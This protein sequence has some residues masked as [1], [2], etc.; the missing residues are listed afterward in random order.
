MN[1]NYLK[2]FLFCLIFLV[3]GLVNVKAIS[4]TVDG[5]LIKVTQSSMAF[6]SSNKPI[7][8]IGGSNSYSKA[9]AFK[10]LGGVTVKN[11]SNGTGY[12]S[13]PNGEYYVFAETSYGSYPSTK[14]T[15]NDSCDDQY[16]N[17]TKTGTFTL[18]RCYIK[19][20][21]ESGPIAVSKKSIGDSCASGYKIDDSK[22]SVKENTCYTTPLTVSGA[23]LGY[24]YCRVVYS[25]TC[26]KGT[27]SGGGTTPTVPAPSISSLSLSSGKISFKSGTK[28]YNVT[29][30]SSVTSVKISATAASGSSF[31]KNYGPR[32]VKLNYGSNTAKL[33]VKNSAGKKVTYTLNITRKDDRSSVN[34]LSNLTVNVGNLEPAFS[35]SNKNYTVNV[36]NE[37]TSITLNATLTDNKSSFASGF[38]PRTVNL[39]EGPN[40]V[41]IKVTSQ[42]G[43]TNVYN[44]T[45]NRA[46][47][48]SICTTQTESLALLK[49]INLSSGIEGVVIDPIKDFDP[50]NLTYDDV[51]VPFDV[52]NLNVEAYT[53]DEGDTV[54]IEGAD[55]LEENVVREVKIT[56]TSKK[57]PNYS[58]TYTLNVTRQSKVV[59]NT[60]GELKELTIKNHDEFEF[61]PNKLSYDIKIKS[62]EKELDI[63]WVPVE[64]TTNCLLEGNEELDIGSKITLTC[65]PQD[66]EVL[67]VVYTINVNGVEKPKNGF[68]I[69]LFV[70]IIILIL[71]Y[72]VLRLLGYRIY[73][74]FAVIGAFFRGLG[75]KFRNMFDK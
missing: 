53:Q 14:V 48:P 61:Q 52:F 23:S 18:E 57:C 24:R 28:K 75:E 9:V 44:I 49:E 70:I 37:V 54:K 5:D 55:N 74:N 39:V 32:T 38:G 10:G 62:D 56:V 58:N 11:S 73:F 16:F 33:Q 50:L 35:S 67:P 45:V 47:T 64:E 1:K 3:A 2:Y 29:V 19:S 72:L 59:L 65:S 25:L 43:A 66:E 4:Y 63:K 13:V 60:N 71:I 20:S 34:T 31:V 12:V 46:T 68:L 22:T 36:N 30:D 40:K 7:F 21:T 51:K 15:V 8:K 41:Y 27:S 6:D 26:S 17:G 69:I 42:K